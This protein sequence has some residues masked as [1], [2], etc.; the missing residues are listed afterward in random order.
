MKSLGENQL[1]ESVAMIG[2][3]SFRPWKACH[4]FIAS[5]G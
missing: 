3:S 2:C 4:E 5:E 1:S